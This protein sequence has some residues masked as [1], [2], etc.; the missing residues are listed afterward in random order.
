MKRL[1]IATALVSFFVIA[2][3]KDAKPLVDA[4]EAYEKDTCACK[5]AD[6]LK[7]AADTYKAATDKLAGEKLTPSEEQAEKIGAASTKAA[8]CA[9][10]LTTKMATDAAAAAGAAVP[11]P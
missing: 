7:K 6:C 2:C 8:E 11:T 9:T 4:A 1:F 10:A 5:D 3:G